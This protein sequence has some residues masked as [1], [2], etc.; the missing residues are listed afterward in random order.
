MRWPQ[1]IC[2]LVAMLIAAAGLLVWGNQ[3][4]HSQHV[5]AQTEQIGRDLLAETNSSHLVSIGEGLRERLV[6]FLAS[7]ATV[8]AVFWGD[9]RAPIG[10]GQAA[11][12]LFLIN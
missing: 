12:R 2:P 11:S 4:R 5:Y 7:P 3:K 8:E 6:S 1:I 9:E 10:D